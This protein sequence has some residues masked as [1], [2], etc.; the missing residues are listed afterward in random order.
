MSQ[1]ELFD[2]IRNNDAAAVA[3]LLDGDPSLLDARQNHVTPILF[4]AYHGHAELARLFLDRGAVL[5]F[6]EACALGDMAQAMRMLD[7][8]PALL[9][10]YTEDGFPPVGLA[11]FFR[12]PELAS[13]LIDR[14]ADVN[15]VARN[16]FGVALFTRPL[17]FA[18]PPRCAFCSVAARKRTPGSSSDTPP[19]TPRPNSATKRLSISCLPTA[20]I[21]TP[22]P[23]T[24]KPRRTLPPHRDT[25]RSRNVFPETRV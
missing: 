1:N 20:P 22:P 10:A 11:V 15:A 7:G 24:A 12:H 21:P 18:M 19:Y 16:A 8:D 25:L 5:L 17:R 3:V 14:G 9:D 4:A 13:A 23:M 6:G 2:A